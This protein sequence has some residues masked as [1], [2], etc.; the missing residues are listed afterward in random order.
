M[1]LIPQLSL[2]FRRRF[3][4]WS[5]IEP[6][7]RSDNFADGLAARVADPLWLLALQWQFGELAG[8]DAG[9]PVKAELQY[10][11]SPLT[12]VRLGAP[13]TEMTLADAPPL[14]T[15]VEREQLPFKRRV[16]PSGSIEVML[17]YRMRIRAGQ[18]LEREIRR[19]LPAVADAVIRSF[20]RSFAIALPAEPALSAVDRA[21]RRY[22]ALMAGR[23]A[24]GLRVLETIRSAEPPAIPAG[25]EGYGSQDNLVVEALRTLR[26]WRAQLVT[27]PPE[28]NPAWQPRRLGYD[29]HARAAD[30]ADGDTVL[31]APNYRNG[32]L[33]WYSFS[34]D[35]APATRIT[36][37]LTNV[38]LPTGL[39]FG[40]M[41]NR[42]WWA[43]EDAAIDF[44]GLDVATT[45]VAKMALMEFA[46]VYADDWFVYPLVVPAGSVTRIASL[47]VSDTFGKVKEIVRG[48]T[49][50]SSSWNRWE[51]FTLAVTADA[52]APGNEQLLLIPPVT[53]FR[54][55]SEPLE[56]VRFARDEGA[57][58]V[59]GIERTVLNALGNPVSGDGA[60]RERQ[61]L[62][63]EANGAAA[64]P[65]TSELS[66]EELALQRYALATAVPYTWV[67]FVP[68]RENPEG[69]SIRLRRAKMLLNEAGAAA[70]PVPAMSHIL[71]GAGAPE[72][73]D[74]EAVLRSGLAVQL[75][76]QRVRWVDGKTYVWLGRGIRMGRGE[77]E[78]GL[79]FDV[80]SS[81]KS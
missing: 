4:A 40:G 57:N 78:S 74:E 68:V 59:W 43:F 6:R 37:P 49:P 65:A 80:V 19:L 76:R 21:T 46:L 66:S 27:E 44:G 45:D 58:K 23:V 60:H 42:R 11:S 61:E 8:S 12:H 32:E 52:R 26:D 39:T 7:C 75:T 72:W 18:R 10:R 9:S 33:D 38:F 13:A 34:V 56:L 81:P 36:E 30:P 17:D 15:L 5:R 77:A 41:P 62:R 71:S 24:D 64:A 70:E 22:V 3:A 1:P 48:R 2:G 79:R 55:E 47:R 54:E 35:Q 53:G 50:G 73:L 14:E 29:F 51:M 31:A 63:R 67:P 28:P 20:R 16:D 25:I 69:T